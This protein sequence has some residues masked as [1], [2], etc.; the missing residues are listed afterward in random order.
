MIATVIHDTA[1]AGSLGALAYVTW[2]GDYRHWLW[3]VPFT[4]FAVKL[5]I[6]HQEEVRR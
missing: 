5:W 3:L 4:W 6:E 2:V 1:A